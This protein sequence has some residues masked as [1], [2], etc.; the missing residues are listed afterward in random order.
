MRMERLSVIDQVA[1]A[2]RRDILNGEWREWL[3][4][5]RRLC[6]DLRVG[7]NTLRAAIRSLANDGLLEV[8][9]GQG[10]R[11][12]AE[13][14]ST[15][16]RREATIGLLT[17]GPLELLFPRQVLWIDGLRG[18]LAE[19]GSLLKIIHGQ[20]YFRANPEMA[21]RRLIEQESCGCWILVFSNRA[22]QRW[23]EENRVPCLIAGSCHEGI[24]LPY[25]DIDYRALCRH[26]I[27][28]LI[29]QG[30][31][32]VAYMTTRPEAAGDI[33]SEEGF[34]EGVRLFA[35]K[36]PAEGRVVHHGESV[37]GIAHA[38]RRLL[39]GSSPPT[40]ILLNNSFLYLAVF[41][42]LSQMGL[43]VPDDVSLVCRESET[44]LAYL[45]PS[46]ACYFQNPHQ[47]ATKV[48]R[49]AEKLLHHGSVDAGSIKLMPEF[50][51]G[52]STKRPANA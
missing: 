45:Q 26:A 30:H 43:K 16:A 10:T 40:A 50:I 33:Y 52:A 21:L 17:P 39:R 28:T 25:V 8:V 32:R 18:Q 11:I 20:Q 12:M 34:W 1:V 46:P 24:T 38:T 4:G 6:A 35:G 51:R 15:S 9:P 37:Q 7:R 27:M 22:A 2:L 29:R 49:I 41:S 44:F 31:Q 48:S 42:T 3:P 36:Q 19:K 14:E 5:E 47:F 23:F 13:G